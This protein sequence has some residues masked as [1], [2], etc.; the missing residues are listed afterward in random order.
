MSRD[1][2]C[3]EGIARDQDVLADFARRDPDVV[4]AL[5]LSFGHGR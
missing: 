3:P 5:G 2:G 4:L 1:Q